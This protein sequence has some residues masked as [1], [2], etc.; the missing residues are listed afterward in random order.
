MN[1]NF[2]ILLFFLIFSSTAIT[3]SDKLIESCPLCNCGKTLQKNHIKL[4]G[5]VTDETN[6]LF[7][8]EN[9]YV[10]I[11]NYP[12][13]EGHILIVPKEHKLSYS[14]LDEHLKYE[15][16]AIIKTLSDII[17]TKNYGL[18]EHGSNMVNAK[19]KACGNSVYHAHMHFIPHLKINQKDLIDLCTIGKKNEIITLKD[20]YKLKNYCTC[21]D[22]EQTILE[23]IKELPTKKPYLFCYYSN[24]ENKSLCIPDEIIQENVC[25]QFFRRV[26]AELFQKD[27][28]NLFWNWKNPNDI[29]KS[30]TFRETIVKKTIEK[31]R[32]KGKIKSILKKRLNILKKK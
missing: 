19:Q 1:K 24:S 9:F 2:K 18:F 22:H 32:D 29:Q 28:E 8:S 27:K 11:D 21:R 25:S 6:I 5:E 15:F 20:G 26:F 30:V 23:H 16:E 17:G 12:V 7:D 10:S 14:V 4:Y 13:C 31:F 3:T